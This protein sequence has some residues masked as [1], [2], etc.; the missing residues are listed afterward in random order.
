MKLLFK[1]LAF[2]VVLVIFVAAVLVFFIPEERIKSEVQKT[3][4][5]QT[6]RTLDYSDVSVSVFPNLGLTLDNVSLSN[7]Q[8]AGNDNMIQIDNV[9]VVLALAPLLQRQVEIKRFVLNAPLIRMQKNAQ[10]QGNWLF[11]SQTSTKAQQQ[12]DSTPSATDASAQKSGSDI[13]ISFSDFVINDGTLIYNDAVSGLQ[14]RIEDVDLTI[15]LP[16]LQSSVDVKGNLMIRGA[17]LQ[18][19]AHLGSLA[20]ITNETATPAR[21]EASIAGTT[22]KF[23]GRYTP[24]AETLL[25]GA[26]EIV[27]KSLAD[28]MQL[29]NADAEAQDYPLQSFTAA[30]NGQLGTDKAVY[31]DLKLNSDVLNVTGQGRF[32]LGGAK[33][34]IGGSY[35]AE[36]LNLDHF[37]DTKKS[38]AKATGSKVKSEG[39]QNA[40][41][42][43]D[44]TPID[45]SALQMVNA[46]L[47]A[48]VGGYQYDG[49]DFGGNTIQLKLNNSVLDLNVSETKA[50][51]GTVSKSVRINAAGNTPAVKINAKM[52]G[53][54][55][56]SFLTYFADYKNLTGTMSGNMN[57]SATGRSMA[58]MTK[59]LGGVADIMFRD[60][61]IEGVNLVDWTKSFQRRL[62]T[63]DESYGST[64]FVEMG[65]QFD[66]NNGIARNSDFR[67][68]GP[69]VEASGS[70][71]VNIPNKT[72]NYRLV[73]KLLPAAQSEKSLTAGIDMPF[74]ITGSWSDPKV[75]PDLKSVIS[76]VLKDP[77][78][79]EQKLKNLKE[80]GK[81]LEDS[82]D[83]DKDQIKENVDQIKKLFDGF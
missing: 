79:A 11:K 16:N 65:G 71:S 69:L 58:D 25:E 27:V 38:K 74:N 63:V 43:W 39:K 68:I 83:T 35:Q 12:T 5:Q 70:G 81:T 73:T 50:F 56:K 19:E 8:W 21:L 42:N 2:L 51:E 62:S 57:L 41:A 72:L 80:A 45:F 75:R 10:G 4:L 28:L 77:K 18:M 31:S 15:T 36:R 6:G 20:A 29:V 52:A 66:I 55:A 26:F 24:A 23:E 60:G 22:L 1:I 30:F 54:N 17:E 64:K 82:F 78:A 76:D 32:D 47:S 48:T 49:M 40:N 13:S 46:D 9:D 7:A 61:N 37:V 53:I 34:F 44:T 59:T 3:V 14:E 67:L 33:P